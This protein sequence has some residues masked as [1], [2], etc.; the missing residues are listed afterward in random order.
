[1]KKK[2]YKFNEITKKLKY[3]KLKIYDSRQAYPN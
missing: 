2:N 3:R 1:M